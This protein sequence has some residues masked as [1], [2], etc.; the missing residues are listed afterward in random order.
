MLLS[1]NVLIMP[2]VLNKRRQLKRKIT[3]KKSWEN[4]AKK[5]TH[6]L[7]NISLVLYKTLPSKKKGK[8]VKIDLQ[9]GIKLKIRREAKQTIRLKNNVVILCF[10][11]FPK[12]KLLH[13]IRQKRY[14][15]KIK[16]LKTKIAKLGDF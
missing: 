11:I 15:S 8:Y 12:P 5:D 13:N 2:W 1:I 10:V 3:L 7:E 6:F 9:P 14:T 16:F 4:K